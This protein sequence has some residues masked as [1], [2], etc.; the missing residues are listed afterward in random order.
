MLYIYIIDIIIII[1]DDDYYYSYY[2]Y[3]NV[4]TAA[5][6]ECLA[7]SS[8]HP[9]LLSFLCSIIYLLNVNNWMHSHINAS[10]SKFEDVA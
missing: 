5:T 10:K 9:R 1:D 6:V 7:L 4:L 8:P 2:Y 3:W